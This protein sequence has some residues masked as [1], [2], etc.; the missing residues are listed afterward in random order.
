MLDRGYEATKQRGLLESLSGSLYGS[1][2]GLIFERFLGLL[3]LILD[4][5]LESFWGV[6]LGLLGLIVG[7]GASWG[8]F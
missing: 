8:S 4:T 5:L 6:F 3:G 2:S 7:P 1:L